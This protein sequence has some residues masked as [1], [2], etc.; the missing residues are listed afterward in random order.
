M[1]KR[2]AFV[3]LL[4]LIL[5]PALDSR[6]HV[7]DCFSTPQ[8]TVSAYWHR[9]IEHRHVEALEC[10]VDG[11]RDA[12]GMLSLPDMVELRPRSFVLS[13]R[14]RGVVDVG[15]EVE[16]RV[17]MGDSLQRFPTGDQLELTGAGWKISR[18]LLFA[19]RP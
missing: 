15:Y 3:P 5:G 6:T 2:Y 1:M 4:A 19:S 18:P 7:A 12:S 10:F 8:A 16:Y 14:G 11:T 17:E 9:M 13:W